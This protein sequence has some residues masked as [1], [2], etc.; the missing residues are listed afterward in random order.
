MCACVLA[1]SLLTT[2]HSTVE[3]EIESERAKERR[4]SQ[5]V[6]TRKIRIRF[7]LPPKQQQSTTQT[8]PHTHVRMFRVASLSVCVLPPL[9]RVC[10]AR[11]R[12]PR[13]S[14]GEQWRASRAGRVVMCCCLT[15]SIQSKGRSK[16]PLR[17]L[18][19]RLL[20][21]APRIAQRLSSS[22]VR[23]NDDANG[24]THNR[25]QC[26]VAANGRVLKTATQTRPAHSTTH[27]S[28][29]ELASISSSS[30]FHTSRVFHSLAFALSL[31]RTASSS[32]PSWDFIGSMSS[33]RYR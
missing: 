30:V 1:S 9:P 3:R 2:T 12:Y 21:S 15:R 5:G 19:H 13:V 26:T 31:S 23:A 20:A 6:T 18:P 32:G 25:I 24:R 7:L 10:K 22:I 33:M 27:S 17:G 11:P 14:F 28:W 16:R 8:H 4:L 29:F